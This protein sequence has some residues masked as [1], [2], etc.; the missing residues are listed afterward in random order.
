M[1]SM[2][3]TMKRNSSAMNIQKEKDDGN[4]NNLN[5]NN[6]NEYSKNLNFDYSTNL[7]ENF[8][9]ENKVMYNS[10][11]KYEE[12][13]SNEKYESNMNRDLRSSLVGGE[14]STQQRL[15]Q[16]KNNQQRL[17][18][19]ENPKIKRKTESMKNSLNYNTNEERERER[20]KV[21]NQAKYNTI[22]NNDFNCNVNNNQNL[23][24]SMMS[25]NQNQNNNNTINN[26]FSNSS[27]EYY[28]EIEKEKEKYNKS[29]TTQKPINH[30]NSIQRNNNEDYEIRLKYNNYI[31]L[32]KLRNSN[33]SLQQ[34]IQQNNN[35]NVNSSSNFTNP[36]L[37]SHTSKLKAYED[38]LLYMK[39]SRIIELELENKTLT[40]KVYFLESS[41]NQ[42]IILNT[43]NQKSAQE[44]IKSLLGQIKIKDDEIDYYYKA[45]NE[46]ADELNTVRKK[47]DDFS[48]IIHNLKRDF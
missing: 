4:S 17:P 23:N 38:S 36:P 11:S 15:Q 5:K 41:L 47:A 25:L 14:S 44:E 9:K 20:E 31:P 43:N 10:K 12:N 28:E 2:S 40:D 34:Q 37:N 26:H 33:N 24:Q 22:N 45:N 46:L 1:T 29:F 18:S 32:E 21:S 7:A 30:V 3:S 39:Q 27:R 48:E 19:P 35:I 16:Y 6:F 42:S 8:E 13:E